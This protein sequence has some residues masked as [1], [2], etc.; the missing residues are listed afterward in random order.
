MI[1]LIHTN[2]TARCGLL[3][4]ALVPLITGCSVAAR[5]E[6]YATASPEVLDRALRLSREETRTPDGLDPGIL[7]AQL[8]RFLAGQTP[9]PKPVVG[10]I[11]DSR[12]VP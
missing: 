10:S 6:L 7:T 2:R 8:E 9:F 12:R 3:V 4:A 5:I 1:A 11:G